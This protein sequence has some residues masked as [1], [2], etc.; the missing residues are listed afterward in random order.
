MRLLSRTQGPCDYVL[1]R[2]LAIAPG[3]PVARLIVL[4]LGDGEPLVVY[5][6][7]LPAAAM[8]ETLDVF[9]A[10]IASEAAAPM[11]SELYAR[12]TGLAEI[13]AEQTFEVRTATSEEARLLTVGPAPV[14]AVTSLVFGPDGTALE[15]R[16]AV[17]RGDRYKFNIERVLRL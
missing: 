3:S 13:R 7:H 9:C 6:S 10:S 14:F 15:Y 17:Y 12:R 5:R 1:C 16:E 11:P 8:Q 2:L 4:G